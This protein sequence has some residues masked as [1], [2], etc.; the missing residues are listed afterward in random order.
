MVGDVVVPLLLV[1]LSGILELLRLQGIT[2]LTRFVFD[3][4]MRTG[5]FYLMRSSKVL[6]HWLDPIGIA[7][8]PMRAW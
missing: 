7:K 8:E 3:V 4:W 2:I 5:V 6:R 1:E